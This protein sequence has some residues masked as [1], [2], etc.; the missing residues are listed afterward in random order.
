MQKK[1]LRVF[2]FT[3]YRLFLAEYYRLE[4]AANAKFS[5][6]YIQEGVGASSAGWFADVI[7]ARINLTGTFLLRLIKLLGLNHSEG[8]YFESLV[9]Y[10]QAS[11]FEDKSRYLEKMLA[12]KELKADLVGKDKFE[13]YSKWFYAAIRELLFIHD[14]RGDY[15]ALA[16]KLNPP[17]RPQQ[18]REAIALLERLEF[19]RSDESGRYRPAS[20]I[21]KKD[22]AFKSLHLAAFLRANMQLGMEA[23]DR[24]DRD[25][26]DVSSLALVLSEEAFRN[27]KDEIGALRKKLLAWSEKTKQGGKVYQCNFQVF[28]VSQ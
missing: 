27:A 25:S 19:I 14:F 2:D 9:N 12:F 5:H 13:Y 6:R 20:P 4:K 26:R 8:E 22:T 28:P 23:L 3:D 17:I 24:F 1:S 18:A 7:K 10:A 15:R 11:S 16:R 21:L